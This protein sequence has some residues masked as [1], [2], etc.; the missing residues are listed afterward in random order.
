MSACMLVHFI[1]SM[2]IHLHVFSSHDPLVHVGT[3]D[4]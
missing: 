4:G 2:V 1:K 3:A